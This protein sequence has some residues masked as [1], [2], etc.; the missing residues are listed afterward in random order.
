MPV[1]TV[2][3]IVQLPATNAA[4]ACIDM[5]EKHNAHW[6]AQLK[7]DELAAL[8]AVIKRKEEGDV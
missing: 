1:P 8:E 5:Y 7:P 6:A 3:V 2:T 4:Q